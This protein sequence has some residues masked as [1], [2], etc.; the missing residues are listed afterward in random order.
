M[1]AELVG[2][3]ME[4]KAKDI[5]ESNGFSVPKEKVRRI[6]PYDIVAYKTSKKFYIEVKGRKTGENIDNF[7]ISNIKMEKLLNMG[8]SKILFLFINPRGFILC[9]LEDITNKRLLKIGGKRI[10]IS[11]NK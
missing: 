2:R 10:Y 11:F 8:N 4:T 5:L 6:M 7:C 9:K 3:E 1:L